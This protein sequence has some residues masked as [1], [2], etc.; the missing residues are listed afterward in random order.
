MKTTPTKRTPKTP[1]IKMTPTK[2]TDKTPKKGNPEPLPGLAPIRDLG[3]VVSKRIKAD[4]NA[5]H[6]WGM[7][8]APDELA[9]TIEQARPNVKNYFAAERALEKLPPIQ[10]IAKQS[11]AKQAAA[12]KLY[13]AAAKARRTLWGNAIDTALAEALEGFWREWARAEKEPPA[14]F[15]AGWHLQKA[16]LLL[17]GPDALHGKKMNVKKAAA[18]PRPK[19]KTNPLKEQVLIAWDDYCE[20]FGE[21]ATKL[22]F[23]EDWLMGKAATYDIQ[24]DWATYELSLHGNHAKPGTI[25]RWLK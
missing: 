15:T 10:K 3:L 9:R 11:K 18:R 20:D 7:T 6:Q 23:A 25:R 2:R 19:R 17:A 14:A 5:R 8:P 13:D 24:T 22:H 21:E 16:L 12:G 4:G 1:K